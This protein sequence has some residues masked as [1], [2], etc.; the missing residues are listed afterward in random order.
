M[1]DGIKL[2]VSQL[3]AV[4]VCYRIITPSTVSSEKRESKDNPKI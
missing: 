4:V 2:T 1:V 3:K